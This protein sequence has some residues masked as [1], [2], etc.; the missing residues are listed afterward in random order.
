MANVEFTIGHKEYTLACR[1]GEEAVLKR[2][3]AMLD[4][5]ARHII[6]AVGGADPYVVTG[7][8]S[9]YFAG[10]VLPCGGHL[11][12]VD[13]QRIFVDPTAAV[14]ALDCTGTIVMTALGPAVQAGPPA[15]S[16]DNS[17]PAAAAP[18]G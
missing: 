9:R 11:R 3:A 15:R 5:E 16:K 13:G 10:A 4:T 17:K 18:N 7:D 1:E 14:G 6:V 12:A 2:A 8:G